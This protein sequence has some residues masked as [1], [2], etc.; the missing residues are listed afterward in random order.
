MT[1]AFTF[2]RNWLDYSRQ[3]DAQR[4]EDATASVASLLG[5][6][7]L[8]GRTVVDI[9]AGS[10]LLS[11]AA[12][13]LGASR[14]VALDRD[15][16]CVEV[17]RSN[18]S[19]LLQGES[20]SRLDVRH[21]DVL[22]R[23]TLPDERFDV[24][25]AWGSLHH[26]SDLWRA[27]ANVTPLARDGGLLAMAIYNRTAFTPMWHGAKRLYHHA[28]SPV[29]VAMAAAL[30][31]P[32]A[33]V[34]LARGRHPLRANRGMSVWYDAVDWLGGLPYEAASADEVIARTGALGF[35][36]ERSR[37]TTRHGC[38]EFVFR[39]PSRH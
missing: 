11:I 38:N 36:L 1:A 23:E 33:A 3:I 34:R 24:V 2:G 21:A 31:A 35:T 14:V 18:A 4:V 30:A 10:G 20:A 7:S 5:L 37:L 39:A 15:P 19:K 27:V 25:Y 32:R 16:Q 29:R 13:R 28:P 17:I 8:S 9:G 22:L 26:T 12:L 6:D